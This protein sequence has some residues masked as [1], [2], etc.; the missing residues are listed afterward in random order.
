MRG[1]VTEGFRPGLARAGST[2]SLLGWTREPP[3]FLGPTEAVAA[4]LAAMEGE[5]DSVACEVSGEGLL[6]ADSKGAGL[7]GAGA[8]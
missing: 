7:N 6:E 4:L 3:S 8:M 2:H 1:S 5:G